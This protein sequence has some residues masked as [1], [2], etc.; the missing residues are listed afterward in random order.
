MSLHFGQPAIAL[1]TTAFA[2]TNDNVLSDSELTVPIGTNQRMRGSIMCPVTLAGA[3]SGAQWQITAPAGGSVY[4]VQYVII[5]GAT[6]AVAQAD[7]II[8]SAAFSNALANAATH[9]MMAEFEIHNGN[10]A[11]NVTLQFAQLVAN[12]AAATMLAGATM[13]VVRF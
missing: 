5:N 7:I 11:G 13:R 6:N 4:Q 12:A 9:V 8:A 1:Q 2:A 10:T 3:A